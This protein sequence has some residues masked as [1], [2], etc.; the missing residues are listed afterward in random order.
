MSKNSFGNGIW[1][2]LTTLSL[3]IA[4]HSVVLAEGAINTGATSP[5]PYPQK[6]EIPAD[7]WSTLS[8]PFDPINNGPGFMPQPVREI[9]QPM[10]EVVSPP[11]AAPVQIPVMVQ[12]QPQPQMPLPPQQTISYEMPPQEK[13][14]AKYPEEYWNCLLNN[15]QGLGSDVAAK[16]I[17]RA[18][19]KKHPKQ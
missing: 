6:E 18:C 16:L 5:S 3:S 2:V 13:A 7:I 15:L 11:L 10:A 4:S 8:S 9:M 14:V 1:I 17:T 19:Q 12:P